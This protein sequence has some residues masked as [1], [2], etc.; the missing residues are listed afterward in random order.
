[1]LRRRTQL[2]GLASLLSWSSGLAAGQ[3]S[4]TTL[5]RRRVLSVGPHRAIKR[6]ADAARLAR[7]GDWVQIDAGDYVGDVAVWQQ[8]DIQLLAHG[9]RVRLIAAGASAERKAIWVLRSGAV[10]MRGFDFYGCAVASGNGAGVR[11][12]SGA[13]RVVDCAFIGNEMGL[14]TNNDAHTTLDIVGSEFA[15]NFRYGAHNHNLYVGAIA[16]LTLADSYL[17]HARIG[18]L[19]KSR[20]A[21]SDVRYSRLTDEASGRASY[22]LDF[23]NGG[24]VTLLGNVIAQSAGTENDTMISFGAEGFRWPRNALHL[25][26][27]TLI[28]YRDLAHHARVVVA[29]GTTVDRRAANNLLVGS[30][31]LFASEAP[32]DQNEAQVAL[33]TF[34]AATDENF[35]LRPGAQWFAPHQSLRDPGPLGLPQ[36]EYVHPRH[37][38]PLIAPAHN[39]GALQWS[40]R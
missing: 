7:D 33:D 4:V 32:T 36:R 1:M 8:H 34:L 16:R 13:A 27:N 10:E 18:H 14:L 29:L 2:L 19:M 30:G 38:R 24:E 17:H 28:D 15:H 35:Q 37:S 31:Q 11:L 22:E 3:D 5:P 23:P 26:S 6:I 21:V 12:E 40:G 9:G 25:F 39:S 20:A